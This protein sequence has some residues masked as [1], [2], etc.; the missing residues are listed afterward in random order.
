MPAS[1]NTICFKSGQKWPHKQSSHFFY[2]GSVLIRDTLCI[3]ELF[4]RKDKQINSGL[5]RPPLCPA[6]ECELTW[7][8]FVNFYCFVL[9][10][11]FSLQFIFCFEHYWPVHKISLGD[12]HS[13]QGV[14][15][16]PFSFMFRL[17]VDKMVFFLA[18]FDRR[19][20]IWLE[21]YKFLGNH[22]FNHVGKMDYLLGN[23]V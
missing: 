5:R 14:F 23:Q 12:G 1:K 19:N 18:G 15:V 2:Q 8:Q 4:C 16:L 10:I 6:K 9:N 7:K 3:T 17:N 11:N 13:W 22:S 21:N 20:A